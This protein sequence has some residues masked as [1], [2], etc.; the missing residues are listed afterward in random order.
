MPA[1]AR[2][3]DAGAVHCSSYTI[4]TG[5]EDVFID[6]R[7]VARNGDLSTVHQ[8]PSGNKCVPHVSQIIATSSTVFI[9]GRPVAVVGDRLSDCTQIVQGSETV[10]I[11]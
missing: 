7:A 4:A 3:G 6:G 1:V 8:K 11:G 10:F 2:Q 9:N 5:S